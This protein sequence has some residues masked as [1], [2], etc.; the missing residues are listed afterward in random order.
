[1]IDDS[2]NT[3]QLTVSNEGATYLRESGTWGTFLA[4]IGFVSLGLFVLLAL[5]A[6]TI[7]ATMGGQT[8]VPTGWISALY[9]CLALLYFFPVF[10]LYRFSARV[11]EAVRRKDSALL[12]GALESMKSLY[13][14]L[15][16]MTVVLLG[17]YA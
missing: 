9:L 17:F 13:K 4:I 1:M 2:L 5:F 7:F 14:F 16:I 12:T 3:N 10:Y 8:G 6:S 15:G 11:K